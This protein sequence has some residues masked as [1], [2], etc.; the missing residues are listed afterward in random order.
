M[1]LFLCIL[2]LL[3]RLSIGRHH[4]HHHAPQDA[5]DTSTV[6][7][8]GD[9]RKL[10][11]I[12]PSKEAVESIGI[13]FID[14]LI[15]KGQMEMAKG[16]FRTQLEVLEKVHPEQ[17]DKYKNMKVEDLAADAVMQQNGIPIGSSIKG[18]E[19]ALK[20]QKEIE[21]NDP[22]EQIAK[23]VFDKFRQQIL[24]GLVAN[25]ISGRNP[26]RMP[27]G[28]RQMQA[29]PEIIRQQALAANAVEE[30]EAPQA[31]RRRPQRFD[32]E[33]EEPSP[34]RGPDDL[35]ARLR[36]SP[37][38]AALLENPDIRSALD[39][40]RFSR[41]MADEEP[42][43]RSLSDRLVS[44]RNLLEEFG[45]RSA[46]ALG[47]NEMMTGSEEEEEE[48]QNT[49]RRAPLKLPRAFVNRLSENP[50]I[51]AA[52]EHLNIRVDDVD[53]LLQPKARIINPHPQPGFLVPRKIPQR[54]RKMIPILVGV[55]EIDNSVLTPLGEIR[56]SPEKIQFKPVVEERSR[57]IENLRN[58]PN[59]AP[60]FLHTDLERKLRGRQML[61]PEQ[62][63]QYAGAAR[64]IHP[65]ML[66]A[67]TQTLNSL[68]RQVEQLIE[69]RPVPPMVWIPKGRHTRLRWTGA[70]E[71]EIPGLG[72]RLIF[73]SL[74]PT[75]PAIN[76]ALSTQGRAREE[77]DTTFKVPNNWNPGD[78]V[79]F[80]V[81]QKSERFMGGT[82]NFDMPAANL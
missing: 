52:L 42:L 54:P 45:S 33:S 34:R 49:V 50:E 72:T 26:F 7:P 51:A 55:P 81:K 79:G 10:A 62:K 75:A 3:V 82:G 64:R 24:P 14:A 9:P 76:T 70:T 38:L 59:I 13:R 46:L 28:G 22:S 66:G 2:F 29:M 57:T 47:I 40:R 12:M 43:G 23:A 80:S 78:E 18:V 21:N 56:R 11:R 37:R 32:V 44:D 60:L 1:Q 5:T 27:N 20:T 35:E 48:E 41:R 68:D 15:K 77:W 30:G 6:T 73:P 65:R 25:I 74:D 31:V 67:K 39:R 17:Y 53:E 61:T 16:A 63:G 36:S 4:H 69:E 8:L 58:N 19:Q 71:R